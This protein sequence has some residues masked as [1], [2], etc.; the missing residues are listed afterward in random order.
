MA[1][2]IIASFS[3]IS[4]LLFLGCKPIEEPVQPINDF[5][6]HSY[7]VVTPDKDYSE[8]NANRV[9]RAVFE[10]QRWYQTAT[11]GVTFE[12]LDEEN[13]MEV[14]FADKVSSSYEE[15]WWN[16]LLAEMEGKGMPVQE[17][18]T[19]AMIW[20]EGIQQISQTATA[21]G[22]ASCNGLCGTAIMPITTI[23]AQTWPPVDMGVVFHE[24]GHALGLSHPV[25]E[26]DLPLSAEEQPLLYS[27]MAQ[28]TIRE[29][30]TNNEHGFLTFEKALLLDNPFM[31][32][33]V[34]TYQ[35]FWQTNI[36]NYP[37]TGPVPQPVINYQ[38]SGSRTVRFSTNI[39]DA[40]LYYWYFSD[41]ATSNEAS[42]THQFEL[43][44]LYNVTLMVTDKNHMAN[45]V[46]Q[47]VQLD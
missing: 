19:I 34:D 39:N 40:L 33:E 21:Q 11:G 24:M 38:M 31:K 47:Y 18:G 16:L 8:E 41:G 6:V 7:Y 28:S 3:I 43:S 32:Q 20:I 45:R 5:K 2:K 9:W 14:Y 10:M 27:V 37:V 23:I 17:P 29:G 22:G 36:L 46:S 4:F 35:D 42:P 44:G 12:I 1:I 15:D 25:E 13:I 30:K 26:A